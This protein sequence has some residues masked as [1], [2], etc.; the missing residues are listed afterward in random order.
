MTSSNLRFGLSR[1]RFLGSSAAAGAALGA[2]S[3]LAACGD[4]GS[5]ATTD[6]SDT[7]KSL[8]V[9]N[10][11]LYIDT[12]RKGPDPFPTVAQFEDETGIDVSYNED[13]TAN[14]EFFAKIRPQLVAGSGVGRDLMVLT[15]WM[16]ARLVRLGYVNEI[17]KTA[18]PNSKN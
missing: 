17:D 12:D 15:D 3:L 4:S 18:I 8:V 14:N 5:E 11:A 2:S 16:A 10:W 7:D 13:I 6:Q 9:S 1:R